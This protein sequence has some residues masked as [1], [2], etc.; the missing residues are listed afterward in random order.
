MASFLYPSLF[1]QISD[2]P[3][4]EENEPRGNV[5]KRD[6][7]DE[8]RKINCKQNDKARHKVEKGVSSESDAYHDDHNERQSEKSQ[9]NGDKFYAFELRS[10][11]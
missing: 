3:T 9:S 5:C 7:R 6:M 11:Q 8:P 1:A 2:F 4:N 10:Y